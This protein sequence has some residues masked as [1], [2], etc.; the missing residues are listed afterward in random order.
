LYRP[1]RARR[2]ARGDQ[3]AIERSGLL[4][5]VPLALPGLTRAVKLQDK[6]ST[7]GFDWRD[8]RAVLAKL[9]E[10]MNE[11]EAALDAGD[12]AEARAEIGDLLFA[13][14]NLARHLG[15]DPEAAI[16]AT[17]AKF[18]RRFAFI[19]S[20]L[21]RRGIALKDA[22]LHEMDALWNLAKTHEV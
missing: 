6:A 9:R 21:A 11:I 10:E 22:G 18:E 3:A 13:V 14:A 17:N 8:P 19:E 2:T 5:D 4:A 1:S 15:A 7:V 12:N 20:E 16:R